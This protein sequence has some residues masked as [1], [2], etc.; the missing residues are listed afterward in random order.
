MSTRWN[1][2]GDENIEYPISNN[3]LE[4]LISLLGSGG[5]FKDA[6]I[7]K[8]LQSVP[9]SKLSNHPL[10]STDKLIRLTHTRGQSLPDWIGL[11]YGNIANFTDGV[12]TPQT[13]EDVIVEI[14]MRYWR[15]RGLNTNRD[16]TIIGIEFVW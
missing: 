13:D 6:P 11:K 5:R 7:E 3:F 9:E 12:A 15:D 10:V 4:T 8:L 14:G 2:W 16:D 1:G